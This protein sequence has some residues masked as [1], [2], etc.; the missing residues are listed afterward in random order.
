MTSRDR[1][2]SAF[3]RF[4]HEYVVYNI[5]DIYD[6]AVTAQ[7]Q[8]SGRYYVLTLGSDGSIIDADI[9]C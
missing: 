1:I 2:R 8:Q 5:D 9:Y 7:G 4:W 6:G 3:L